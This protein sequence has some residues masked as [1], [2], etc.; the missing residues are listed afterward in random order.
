M[1]DTCDI[2]NVIWAPGP[3]TE[4]LRLKAIGVELQVSM[5]LAPL[6]VHHCAVLHVAKQAYR[7]L[8]I[9]PLYSMCSSVSPPFSSLAFDQ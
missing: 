8:K 4:Q 7:D 6:A 1:S 9:M 5:T 3:P 2:L